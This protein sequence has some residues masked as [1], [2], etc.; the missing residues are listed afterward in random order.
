[1]GEIKSE[2]TEEHHRFNFAEIQKEL[3]R[4]ENECSNLRL[5]MNAFTTRLESERM[6]KDEKKS[7][8][9]DTT[10]MK[11]IISKSVK[12]MSSTGRG[13]VKKP[14][15]FSSALFT[16]V[17]NIVKSIHRT[18]SD[19]AETDT[20]KLSMALLLFCIVTL[21]APPPIGFRTDYET[22]VGIQHCICPRRSVCADDL[23]SM[24]LLTIA[25]GSAFFDYPLYVLLFIS[26]AN[27]LRNSLDQTILREWIN[28]ADLHH[29]HVIFGK[30]V[31]VETMSHS[32]FHIWRWIHRNDIQ[33][34]WTTTT[35]VTGLLAAL[36]TPL[37]VWPMTVPSLK[38]SIRYEIR[39]G[40]HYLFIPW[41]LLLMYHAPQRIFY[42]I[43]IPF[44][45]YAADFV[46]GFFCKIY[47]IK[48]VSF[49]K[50]DNVCCSL[51][52][53]NPPGF[54]A[55]TDASYVYLVLPWISKY[56]FHAFTIFPHSR[57]PEKT[58]ICI[59]SA[60]DWT[61]KLNEL[62]QYPTYKP[63]YVLG[64]FMSPFAAPVANSENII[65]V[66][67]GIGIT[68]A[69]STMAFYKETRRVNLIWVCREPGLVEFFLNDYEFD[70]DAFI[71]IFYTGRRRLLLPPHMPFNI[72]IF[73]ERPDFESVIAGIIHGIEGGEALPE[74]LHHLGKSFTTMPSQQRAIISLE[75]MM[76]IYSKES[77]FDYAMQLDNPNINKNSMISTSSQP[78]ANSE[79]SVKGK[80]LKEA[81]AKFIGDLGMILPSELQEAF[82]G[83]VNLEKHET[84]TRQTFYDFMDNL[85]NR[86][87]RKNVDIYSSKSIFI[88]SDH[89]H[90]FIR[91][92]S[93]GGNKLTNWQMLYCGGSQAVVNILTEISDKFS[94]GL[95]LEKFDW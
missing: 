86:N 80:S 59:A 79:D 6:N 82:T 88:K 33:Q 27:N 89:K 14:G 19:F 94:I 92:L 45:I 30:C 41:A 65:A 21:W 7:F 50:L 55:H 23:L 70:D 8:T 93:S 63:A 44:G 61:K 5:R 39:K 36:I 48:S 69:L 67:S 73:T 11:S 43:G 77:V 25:R 2:D 83:V 32:F 37:I 20:I 31:G 78:P 90:N 75:R 66:A 34:L 18:L 91:S 42:F 15:L 60:G 26:K 56:E 71:L 22:C 72:F 17:S 9:R 10:M 95:A 47:Y 74:D 54:Q 49:H 76:S 46:I 40:L 58:E 84:V 68:P 57:D 64:P 51:T 3:K 12:Y 62:I 24:I 81:I 53:D 52:F 28:F 85:F 4:K 29:L 87:D 35:G 16:F 1:M 13:G 38:S